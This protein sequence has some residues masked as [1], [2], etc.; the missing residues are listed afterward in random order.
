[1]FCLRDYVI[2]KLLIL[3]Y[4]NNTNLQIIKFKSLNKILN[5]NHVKL[6]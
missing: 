2:E 4:Y 5:K 6:K 3:T 1:M